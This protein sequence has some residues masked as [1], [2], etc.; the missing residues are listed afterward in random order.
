MAAPTRELRK[1]SALSPSALPL[2]LPFSLS[3][4][5]R[6][7]FSF[8]ASLLSPCLSPSVFRR[9][10]TPATSFLHT[11]GVTR[12]PRLGTGVDTATALGAVGGGGCTV[13]PSRGCSQT[14][15][16]E[17]RFLAGNLPPPSPPSSSS[18][19]SSSSRLCRLWNTWRPILRRPISPRFVVRR[20]S[21]NARTIVSRDLAS[22]VT[23]HD[24]PKNAL[25]E[26]R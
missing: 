9:S 10:P 19:S 2:S 13:P 25:N 7:F 5:R 26:H 17:T 4:P 23:R 21:R 15:R 3:L 24:D 22:L 6:F 1:S 14:F 16:A 8:S 11:Y 18:S 12:T 20:S